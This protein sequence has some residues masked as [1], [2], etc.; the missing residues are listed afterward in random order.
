MEL[1]GIQWNFKIHHSFY[2][3][4]KN[5]Q[6]DVGYELPHLDSGEITRAGLTMITIMILTI[7]ITMIVVMQV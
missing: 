7:T 5:L 6:Y 1:N 3:T 4:H 2:E